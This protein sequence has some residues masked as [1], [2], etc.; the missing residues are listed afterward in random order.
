LQSD[1]ANAVPATKPVTF[2]TILPDRYF[3]KQSHVLR[4]AVTKTLPLSRPRI[5][6]RWTL[7]FFKAGL[8]VQSEAMSSVIRPCTIS[9]LS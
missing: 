1:L 8:Q 6:R 9:V 2:A 4:E 5:S 7:Q 3:E